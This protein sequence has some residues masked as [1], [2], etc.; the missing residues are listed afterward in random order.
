MFRKLLIVQSFRKFKLVGK[1]M[2]LSWKRRLSD[3]LEVLNARLKI[4]QLR[5]YT[6][7]GFCSGLGL[8]R[9][10]LLEGHSCSGMKGKS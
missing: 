5:Q 4:L 10:G 1:E 7:E 8:L 2:P 9:T 3:N 6:L